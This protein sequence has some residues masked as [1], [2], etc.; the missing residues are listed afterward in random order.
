[1]GVNINSSV[2]EGGYRELS[3]RC[4]FDANVALVFEILE[5]EEE[6]LGCHF[7]ESCLP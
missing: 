2:V 3:F 4:G 5:G 6:V 7:G 1:M